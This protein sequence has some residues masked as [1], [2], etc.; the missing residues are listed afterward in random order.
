MSIILVLL[1]WFASIFGIHPYGA[2]V[3]AE[4]YFNELFGV[5]IGG[6]SLKKVITLANLQAMEA[7]QV[8]W[9]C[10]HNKK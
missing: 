3:T 9:P 8:I 1:S 7:S 5:K 4:N 10:I 2:I 6:F